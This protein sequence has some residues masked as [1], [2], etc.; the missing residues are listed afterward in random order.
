MRPTIRLTTM[1]EET[2]FAPLGVL[3]YCLTRT[4]FLEPVF[5]NGRLPLKTVAHS[6][7]SKLLDSD[8][9]SLCNLM[10][11]CVLISQKTH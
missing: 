2:H 10:F 3:G 4:H 5:K 9:R 1:P 6:P 8:S 7:A 11:L